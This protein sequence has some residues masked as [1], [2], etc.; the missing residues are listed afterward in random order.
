MGARLPRP[1][2]AWD[3]CL[4]SGRG[5]Q[6]YVKQKGLPGVREAEGVTRGT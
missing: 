5:Y 4:Q 1:P 3:P 2:T 6:G